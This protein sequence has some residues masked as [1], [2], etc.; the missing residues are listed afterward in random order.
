MTPEQK[1]LVQESFEQLKP[2]SQAVGRLFY[3]RLFDLDP[4]LIR[5]FKN[6]L[7]E[8]ARKL[9]RM[10][11]LALK[12]LDRPDGLLVA[13][14][15]LGG[16]EICDSVEER[17][18]QTV[19]KAMLWTLEKG[20]GASFTPE[21]KEAWRTVYNLLADVMQRSAVAARRTSTCRSE[22]RT[23]ITT[24]TGGDGCKFEGYFIA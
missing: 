1:S 2:I 20:L 4:S 22:A 23:L 6:D 10:I 15:A 19:R 21:V 14:G 3:V 24:R 18:Y 17:H 7:D 13:L 12:G 8:Q 11:G 9:M 16:R 5:P